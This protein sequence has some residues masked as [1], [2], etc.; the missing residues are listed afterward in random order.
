MGAKIPEAWM[1]SCTMY[2][3]KAMEYRCRLKSKRK[4]SYSKLIRDFDVITDYRF[5]K[6]VTMVVL[7]TG[8]AQEWFCTR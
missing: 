5:W 2:R 4:E 8:G 6:T 7:L 3:G 1:G